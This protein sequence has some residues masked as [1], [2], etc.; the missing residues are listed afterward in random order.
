[1]AQELLVDDL[2]DDGQRI[3]DEFMTDGLDVTV[4]F[5]ATSDERSWRLYIASP[6]FDDSDPGAAANFIYDSA[7]KLPGLMIEPALDLRTMNDRNPAA[8]AAIKIAG[9]PGKKEGIRYRGPR[10]G[11]L[12]IE[13]AYIY[14]R[15]AVPLRQSFAISYVRQ[16]ETDEWSATARAEELYRGVR[17]NG[18]V[19]Y[20]TAQYA[21]ESPDEPKFALINVFVEVD[22]LLD[23]RTLRANPVLMRRMIEEAQSL[24]DAMF[25]RRHPEAFIHHQD[26]ALTPV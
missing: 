1:M 17:L 22:P 6:A 2:I 15:P 5:W 9:R 11:N 24:A 10:L 20:F 14:P 12:S 18:A 3:I 21:G 26:A 16:G 8:Q 13:E 19:S 25:Q 4:G 23:D 7:A